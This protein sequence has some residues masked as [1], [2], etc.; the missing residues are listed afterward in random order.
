MKKNIGK[1]DKMIRV[2]LALI[3]AA[4]DFFEIVTWEYSWIFTVFAITLLVTSLIN[5]CPAYTLLGVN[6]CENKNLK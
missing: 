5:F 3:L 1:S 6:T 2:I 4:I